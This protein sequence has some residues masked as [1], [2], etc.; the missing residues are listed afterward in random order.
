MIKLGVLRS[1]REPGRF[2]RLCVF[3]SY[4]YAYMVR[5]IFAVMYELCKW[6][7]LNVVPRVS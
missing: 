1:P 5:Y 6:H 3:K 4:L 2:G 7:R